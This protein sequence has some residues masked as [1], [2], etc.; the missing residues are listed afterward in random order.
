MRAWRASRPWLFQPL[1]STAWGFQPGAARGLQ[2]RCTSCRAW[3]L[4]ACSWCF[5]CARRLETCAWSRLGIASLRHPAETEPGYRWLFLLCSWRWGGVLRCVWFRCWLRSVAWGSGGLALG[6]RGSWPC[7]VW[8]VF[9]HQFL[10]Q[11]LL[12]AFMGVKQL[13]DLGL[14][15]IRVVLG[16]DRE[17]LFT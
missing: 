2:P 13:V 3:R 17:H 1:C 10:H 12:F 8:S 11:G 15:K 9:A 14:L 5:T 6:W 16:I 4:E 7:V